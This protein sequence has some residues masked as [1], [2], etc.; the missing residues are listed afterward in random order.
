[1]KRY[2]GAQDDVEH[3]ERVRNVDVD[4]VV[5]MGK[6]TETTVWRIWGT[7]SHSELG[8]ISISLSLSVSN[9]IYLYLS[10]SLYLYPSIYIHQEEESFFPFGVVQRASCSA[11]DQLS[12]FCVAC[13][14]D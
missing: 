8:S 12:S 6:Y 9:Y 2:G 13:V 3:A 1:M 7:I 14:A 5:N 10:L 11:A 4:D